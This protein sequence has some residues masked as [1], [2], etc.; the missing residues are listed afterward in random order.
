MSENP[1]TIEAVSSALETMAFVTSWPLDGDPSEDAPTDPLF[2]AIAYEGGARGTLEL[3]APREF[4]RMLAANLLG[5]AGGEAPSDAQALDA[6]CELMN[7]ACG[8]IL[9][10]RRARETERFDMTIPWIEQIDG[11]RGWNEFT[12]RPGAVVLDAE[13]THIAFR[14]VEEHGA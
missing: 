6:L 4:A 1:A 8:A 13:G 9:R 2:A 11:V 14:L 12:A 3:V 7:V 10:E 5:N